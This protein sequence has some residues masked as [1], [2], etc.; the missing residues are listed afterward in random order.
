MASVFV[1][2][3]GTT[4]SSV[5]NV[6]LSNCT[7]TPGASFGVNGTMKQNGWMNFAVVNNQVRIGTGNNAPIGGSVQLE[8]AWTSGT[9]PGVTLNNLTNINPYNTSVTWPTSTG[10]QQQ[11]LTPGQETLLNGISN[12]PPPPT[13]ASS[14]LTPGT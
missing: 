8:I 5:I 10:Y 6:T 12:S 9:T 4:T 11:V 13:N 7:I 2:F 1:T 14:V 3:E